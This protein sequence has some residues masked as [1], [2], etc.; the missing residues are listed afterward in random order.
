[1]VEIEMVIDSIRVSLMNYQRV[2]MLKEKEGERYLPIWIGP[3]EADAIAVKLENISVP[4]PL[5]HDLLC[6]M[7]KIAKVEIKSA[8]MTKLENDTHYAKLVVTSGNKPHD[9]DCRPSDAIAMAVRVGAPIF[10]DEKVLKKAGVKLDPETGKPIETTGATYKEEQTLLPSKTEKSKFE[11]F[12]NVTQEIMIL[13]E[14]EAKRLKHNFVGT[15]HLLLGL[16]KSNP[17]TLNNLGI[18]TEEIILKI[19]NFIN[20]TLDVEDANSGLTSS[21]KN[22]I[23]FSIEEAQ[24][25]AAK[26]VEAEHILLGFIREQDGIYSQILKGYNINSERVYIELIRSYNQPRYGQQEPPE[27]KLKQS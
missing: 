14:E 7:A 2:V 23:K 6:N 9:V 17:D 8:V 13:A 24:K 3:A 20:Q 22:V 21:V 10:A 4:R 15:G 19:E 25:L 26:N 27:W 12:S 5:T 11:I 1:M 18:D 16:I